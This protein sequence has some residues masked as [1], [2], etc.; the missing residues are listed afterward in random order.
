MQVDAVGPAAEQSIEAAFAAVAQVD[1]LMSFHD[2]QSELS[3]LNREAVR[4]PQAVHPWTWAVLRRALKISEAS[5]GLF[6][7]TVAPLLVGQGL[8]PG[9]AD[10]SLECGVSRDIVLM[11]ER[12]VF[13]KRPMLVDLGGIAKG[14]A[15]DVAIHE[16]RRADCTEGAVNAGGDLRRFGPVAQ[17]I[18][19]RK[20]EG[21]AKVAELR[22]GAIATSAPHAN[23]PD[24]LAQPLGSIFDPH[25]RRA[26]N[27]SGAVMVAAPSCVI[28]D[29]LT[30]VAA[31]AGPSSAPLLARFGA[32]AVWVDG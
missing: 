6:D 19:L 32:R 2:R 24:R 29:A 7:V 22:C 13:F 17:P 28:A 18:H 21:L 27:G 3:R 14:F 25:G 8:L 12:K 1:R 16:L 23:Q 15:V 4:G 11:P 20:E 5:A 9:A 10:A 31:L 26:W 30:K